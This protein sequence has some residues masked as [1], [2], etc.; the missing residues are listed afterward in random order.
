MQLKKTSLI[1]GLLFISLNNT[2]LAKKPDY[3]YDN[4]TNGSQTKVIGKVL[5]VPHNYEYANDNSKNRYYW[6]SHT[7]LKSGIE[8]FGYTKTLTQIHN[9]FL[10]V[11]K[12]VTRN[13]QYKENCPK[14]NGKWCGYTNLLR[15][16]INYWRNDRNEK[17][18]LK[19]ER[20]N[21]NNNKERFWQTI[22][23]SINNRKVLIITSEKYHNGSSW[24]NIG[25]YMVINGY[26]TSYSK[27]TNLEIENL[28]LVTLRDPLSPKSGGNLDKSFSL[29]E[30]WNNAK[31]VNNNIPT[32][33][34]YE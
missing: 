21:F 19:A 20:L 23:D 32:I 9:D 5:N 24:A 31:D 14:Y 10:N 15:D 29:D 2:S 1:I 16:T 22:K 18:N 17:I 27:S 28:R 6:C 7:A 11:D 13:Y 12:N 8:A 30:L 4:I 3:V 33:I 26:T 25:H 34:I